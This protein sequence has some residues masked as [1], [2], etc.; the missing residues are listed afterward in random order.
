MGQGNNDMDTGNQCCGVCFKFDIVNVSEIS[1]LTFYSAGGHVIIVT[2]V[3]DGKLLLSISFD[4]GQHFQ[5]PIEVMSVG[6]VTYTQISAK[7]NQFVVV[8]MVNDP[9]T[10]TNMKKA[11]SGQ[12]DRGKLTFNCK[13]CVNHVVKGR[14]INISA[15]FR[16]SLDPSTGKI[17][18][19][20]SVD[21]NYYFNEQ[22]EVCLDCNGHRCL[23]T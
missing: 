10:K 9:N 15:G 4:C 7:D 2:Y 14:L 5:K 3:K 16:P 22:G 23:V 8:L 6:E 21:F 13:E 12:I 19:E 11:V 1:N 17:D 18:G 20:E